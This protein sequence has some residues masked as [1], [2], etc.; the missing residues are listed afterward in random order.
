MNRFLQAR[1]CEDDETSESFPVEVSV[2]AT[3]EHP[4]VFQQKFYDAEIDEGRITTNILQ[5]RIRLLDGSAAWHMT[6]GRQLELVILM[7]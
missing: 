6:P 2:E 4:P 1:R 7:F 5:V 3:N